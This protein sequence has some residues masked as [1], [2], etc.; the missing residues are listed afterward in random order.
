MEMEVDAGAVQAQEQSPPP[1]PP[2]PAELHK[3]TLSA[4]S[5]VESAAKAE[6]PKE[7]MDQLMNI[8]ESRRDAELASTPLVQRRADATARSIRA[9]TAVAKA[10]ASHAQAS[11][12]L[13]K[14][15]E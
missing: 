3:A 4:K 10:R 5:M 7:I 12:A 8:F 6:A 15:T 13:Q 14:W 9:E 2:S 11:L 1:K